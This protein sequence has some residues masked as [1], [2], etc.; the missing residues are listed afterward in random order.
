MCIRDRYYVVMRVIMWLGVDTTL[1]K[2]SQALL[3]AVFL[4]IPYWRKKIFAKPVRKG[5]A[6]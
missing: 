1:L 3:V 6:K 4:A 2:L 5:A